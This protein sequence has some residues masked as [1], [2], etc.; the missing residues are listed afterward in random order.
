AAPESPRQPV[1][2]TAAFRPCGG[3]SSGASGGARVPPRVGISLAS[4]G[5]V[6]GMG[7]H[8][9]TE[10]RCP[11]FLRCWRR[12]AMRENTRRGPGPGLKFPAADADNRWSKAAGLPAPRPFRN[13]E[14]I[15]PDE[16]RER[17]RPWAQGGRS[18]V[19]RAPGVHGRRSLAALG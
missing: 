2:N 7:R 15:L 6:G 5:P 11:R 8:P 12:A 14:A 19:A 3:L 13:T 18:A 9:A 10:A 17:R 1:G 4:T 16:W